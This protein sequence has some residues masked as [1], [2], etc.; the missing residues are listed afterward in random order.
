MN[1][2]NIDL[3]LLV[4]LQQL[5]R[6]RHVSKAAEQLNMSQPA[7]S[8]A[9][10]RL[11]QMLGDELLVRTSQGY[12]LSAR[13]LLL[14]AQLDQLLED[15]QRLITEP[16]FIPE[17]SMQTVRFYGPDPEINHYLPPLFAQIRQQAP[18]MRMQVRSDPQDNFAL[19]EA[20]EVHFVLTALQ[21]EVN[22]SHLYGLKLTDL[23]F[24]VVMNKDHPLAKGEVS[25]EDYLNAKHGMVALTGRGSSLLEQYLMVRGY[26]GPGEQ[27]DTPLHLSSFYAI[28]SFAEHSDVLFHVPK[29]FTE[30]VIRGRNL[31]ARDILPEVL[32]I[33]PNKHV[34][35]YWHQR[36]HQDPMC[37]WVR[38]LLRALA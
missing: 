22:I 31:I 35:L 14:Q 28:S 6:E 33:Q 21:P 32:S 5:L 27:L 13:A 24:T 3:N 25:I 4:V 30:D 19:L 9:L 7:V 18:Q 38:E 29:Y 11:R 1:L 15:T 20:G 36:H 17:T 23:V 26:L 16:E 10:Q 37:C 2:R 34:Y 8:R 12:D